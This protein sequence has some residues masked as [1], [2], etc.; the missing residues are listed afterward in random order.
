MRS[1]VGPPPPGATRGLGVIGILLSLSGIRLEWAV[2]NDR[3]QR[4]CSPLG[5]QTDRLATTSE[6]YTPRCITPR[7]EVCIV[8]PE[9]SWRAQAQLRHLS[10][11]RARLG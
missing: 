9:Q 5:N 3:R 11:F 1:E 2:V 7:H 4:L 6:G 8:Q 10:A